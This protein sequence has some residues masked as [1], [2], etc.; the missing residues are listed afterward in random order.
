MPG[1]VTETNKLNNNSNDGLD[2]P[3]AISAEDFRAMCLESV[4][5]FKEGSV[6][7]GTIIGIT[8]DEVIVDIGYKSEGVIPVTEFRDLAKVQIGD[9]IDVYL[10]ALEDINGMVVL[11]KKVAD[12]L[13]NWE[14]TVLACEEGRVIE[15]TIFK[16]VK[17]GF[18]VDIGMEAFLPASQ[19]DIKPLRDMDPFVG[20][21]CEFKVIKIDEARKNIVVSRR[22]LLEERRKKERERL[23]KEIQVGDL[24]PGTV[25]NITDF[26]AFIDLNGIDG[27][28]HITDITWKRISHPSEVLAIGDKVEVVILDFDREKE[29]VSLGL[30]QKTPDPWQ[31]VEEKYPVGSKVRGKVVNLMPYGAFLELEEGIEGL[32]HISELS[33]SKRVTNPAEILKVSDVVDAMVLNIDKDQRRISLGLKQVTSNPWEN[34]GDRYPVGKRIAGKV[35]N[36]AS[37]GVFVEL[38]DGIDG[39]IHVSDISWTKKVSNPSELFKKGDTIETMVL[40]V[41]QENKKIALGIKQLSSDPWQ[42]I[43]EKYRVGQKVSCT[44]TNITS[45]GAF[46]E[47]EENVEGLIHISQISDRNVTSVGDYLKVGDT[48]EAEI[49]KIEP[50]ERKLGLSTREYFRS[51]MDETQGS[52]GDAPAKAEETPQPPVEQ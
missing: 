34:I 37:Y 16:K 13:Q 12:K 47:L 14:R 9:R 1:T 28:L 2:V 44:I 45:F 41:D 40:S 38:E 20:V 11:S 7:P 19:V 24:R 31:K 30:K 5:D 18:M 52:S 35:R 27:L 22:V 6:V 17:G 21:N 26:G 49:I 39:L 25:K 36:I 46:A 50:E 10:E 23:L 42:T 4:K 48:V 33:W 43:P 3:A 51:R 32:I 8:K 29:R 15:G